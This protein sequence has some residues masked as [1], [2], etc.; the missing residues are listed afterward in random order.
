MSLADSFGLLAR[1]T[2][3][4]RDGQGGLPAVWQQI[5]NARR[6]GAL[7]R[8]DRPRA[9]ADL[10]WQAAYQSLWGDAAQASAAPDEQASDDDGLTFF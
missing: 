7:E 2:G 9:L 3:R 1:G 6:G 8:A 4:V 10:G 5:R